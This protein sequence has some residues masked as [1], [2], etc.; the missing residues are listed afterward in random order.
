MGEQWCVEWR[1][2]TSGV[3]CGALIAERESTAFALVTPFLTSQGCVV[4][5]YQQHGLYEICLWYRTVGG[6]AECV[7][8]EGAISAYAHEDCRDSW[9]LVRR[10]GYTR[11][12]EEPDPKAP[13]GDC[14]GM[15]EECP[16]LIL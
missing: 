15:E 10:W 3:L 13:L 2:I 14:K 5:R 6:C 16:L 8:R 11:D 1:G 9:R 12:A 4:G 7:G